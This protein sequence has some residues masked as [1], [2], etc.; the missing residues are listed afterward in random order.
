MKIIYLLLG[1]L[2]APKSG[3][4]QY[5]AII[6]D[7]DGWTNVRKE[8]HANSEVI[9]RIYENEVFW[10]NSGSPSKDWVS[11]E[12]PKNDFGFAEGNQKEIRGYIHVSRLL[13]L[14]KLGVY[15]G[16]EFVF[17]YDFAPF[18]ST[19]RLITRGPDRFVSAID[20]R[21]VWGRD[22]GLPNKTVAG[23]YVEF[24][25]HL[26]PIHRV[27]YEDIFQC[28]DQV[29]IYKNKDTFFVYQINGDGAG[30]YELAWVFDRGGL[31]QRLV[32]K[33]D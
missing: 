19:H 26:I 24:E 23:I 7:A 14:K 22:G 3:L 18:D 21:R 9:H 20:G 32:G 4:S 33:K 28:A 16:T 29:T 31:K 1:V 6:Q 13:P 11:V 15:T 8:P 27:F 17:R 30:T 10:Y 25:G 12:V 5:A 2:L